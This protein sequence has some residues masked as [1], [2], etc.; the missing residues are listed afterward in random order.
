MGAR[1]GWAGWAGPEELW[2]KR[3]THCTGR[4]RRDRCSE[5]PASGRISLERTV[6]PHCE[7]PSLF[8][9]GARPGTGRGHILSS[10]PCA[11]LVHQGPV[12][13]WGAGAPLLPSA[14]TP[15]GPTPAWAQRLGEEICITGIIWYQR[16]PHSARQGSRCSWR[17]SLPLS[18]VLPGSPG[19]AGRVNFPEALSPPPPR[20]SQAAPSPFAAHPG[21]PGPQ[22]HAPRP[23]PG[24][25]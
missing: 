8:P 25:F 7:V 3:G 16:R 20:T 24:S 5:M 17:V 2:E 18:H 15:H 13:T 14:D 4:P 6:T 12:G 21:A 10:V 19:G 22:A 9:L 1:P 11:A 23:L